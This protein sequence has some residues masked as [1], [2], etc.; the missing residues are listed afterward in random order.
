MFEKPRNYQSV[1]LF[2]SEIASKEINLIAKNYENIKVHEPF[3]YMVTLDVD[4]DETLVAKS[5][6]SKLLSYIIS[7]DFDGL[8]FEVQSFVHKWIKSNFM[9]LNEKNYRMRQSV[10]S[11]MYSANKT[12]I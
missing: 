2:G 8:P 4:L 12:C 6:S 11:L 5:V 1:T 9:Y 10:V 3:K 7:V